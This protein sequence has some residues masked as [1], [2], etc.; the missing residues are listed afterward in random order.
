MDVRITVPFIVN[1]KI[2]AHSL[3][4]KTLLTE[5]PYQINLFIT[6]YFHR[7]SRVN[8]PCRL[9]VFS[10][11]GFFHSVPQY[12]P[13]FKMRRSIIGQQNFLM[14][15]FT[16][17]AVIVN[18]FVVLIFDFFTRNVCSLCDRACVFPAAYDFDVEMINCY[19]NLPFVLLCTIQVYKKY[20]LSFHEKICCFK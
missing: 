6:R 11:F 14:Y 12:R 3:C 9:T 20:F 8:M 7:Q 15:N 17:S 1:C 16:F 13:L 10:R 19:I 18:F 4:N 5:F 2:G